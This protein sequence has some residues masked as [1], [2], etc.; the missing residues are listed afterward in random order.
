MASRPSTSAVKSAPNGLLTAL[1]AH[2][3][4]PNVLLEFHEVV[5]VNDGGFQIVYVL[6]RLL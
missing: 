3:S 1:A 4:I 5:V 6:R 2:L